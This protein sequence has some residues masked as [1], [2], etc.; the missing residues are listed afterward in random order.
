LRVHK[1]DITLATKL[2][3]EVATNNASVFFLVGIE[4]NNAGRITRTP[5]DHRSLCIIELRDQRILTSHID[6]N[7]EYGSNL[8]HSPTFEK[9]W[10]FCCVSTNV[11]EVNFSTISFNAS[12]QWL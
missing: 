4:C 8:C 12:L 6:T 1:N 9:C 5:S 2:L 11:L 10:K 3:N 7:I